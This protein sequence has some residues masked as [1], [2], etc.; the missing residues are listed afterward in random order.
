MSLARGAEAWPLALVIL[1]LGH[2]LN[3][4]LAMIAMFAHGV[5]LNMLEFC[6]NLG[7][8]WTGYRYRPY[9]NRMTRSNHHGHGAIDF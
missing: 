3:M 1:V 7:M 4:G 9:F 6:N 5:R 8:K 2:S